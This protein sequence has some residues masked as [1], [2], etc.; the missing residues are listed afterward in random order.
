M[1]WF[2]I[3][4]AFGAGIIL[5]GIRGYNTRLYW[6]IILCFL[7]PLT[8]IGWI[9]QVTPI[10]PSWIQSI[11]NVVSFLIGWTAGDSIISAIREG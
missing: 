10:E 7:L 1:N 4:G 3:C 8:I 6:A 2:E 9:L 11:A 5:G